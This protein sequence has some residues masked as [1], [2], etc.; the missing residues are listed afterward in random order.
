MARYPKERRLQRGGGLFSAVLVAAVL[1]G[2]L[3][4]A[5]GAAVITFGSALGVPASKDTARDLA[6]SGA[7]IALPGSIFH[8]PHDGADTALWN[9]AQVAPASGQVTSVRLEGCANQPAGAPAP[10]TQIHFQELAPQ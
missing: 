5:A 7:D 9:A 3:V 4:P 8:I 1:L 2:A 10:L 6:Y